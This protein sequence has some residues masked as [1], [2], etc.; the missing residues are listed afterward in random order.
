ML[1]KGLLH[2]A[3]AVYFLGTGFENCGIETSRSYFL[4][5]FLLELNSQ[6]SICMNS[7]IQNK[8]G[9]YSANKISFYKEYFHK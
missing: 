5:N 1:K 4:E 6:I 8:A 3:N 7:V 2:L 9:I